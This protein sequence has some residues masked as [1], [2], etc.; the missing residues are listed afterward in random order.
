MPKL[1]LLLDIIICLIFLMEYLMKAFIAQNRYLYFVSIDSAAD[2][3]IIV[4]PLVF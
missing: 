3:I 4:P 1:Y 2:L